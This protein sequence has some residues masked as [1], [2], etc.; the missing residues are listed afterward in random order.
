MLP[1]GLAAC[2]AALA[3]AAP[4]WAAQV[5]DTHDPAAG[6][7]PVTYAAGGGEI[8]QLTVSGDGTNVVFGDAFP[9][10]PAVPAPAVPPAA[11]PVNDCTS[12]GLAALCPFGAVTVTL[13][14]Q[15]DTI[16]TGAGAPALDIHGG[17][18][19]DVLFDPV[20]SPGTVFNGDAGVDRTDYTGRTAS[21]S[22]SLNGVADDGA[23]GEGDNIAGDEVVGGAGDDTITG[24]ASPNGL[25]G[26]DGNDFV[27]GGGGSDVL[28]GGAGNDTLDGG[29]ADDTLRGGDG[30]DQLVGG[31]GNDILVGGPGADS[32][33][34]GDGNDNIQAADGIAETID[35]GPGIDTVVADL[36][37]NGVTDTRIGCENVSGPAAPPPPAAPANR[38][39]GLVPV[40]APGVANP[41]DLTPPSAT[42]KQIA[43][44]KLRT[45]LARGVPLDVSCA[46]A[47]GVSISL[48][49]ERRT[50]RRLGLDA[51]FPPVVVATVLARRASPGPVRVRAR[52]TKKAKAALRRSR[53]V[54][55]TAQALVSDA[56][57]N[58]TLLT[59][60]VTLVR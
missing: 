34:G 19:N 57:G 7:G 13:G 42:L 53:R 1:G 25:T 30:A 58:G 5:A 22:V 56:S 6:P 31:P 52:F 32:I 11:T 41:A 21:L 36:G 59:R 27:S 43:R 46:E 48:S 12:T 18:G 26:G 35:C 8:N 23:S 33:S 60:R 39:A 16:R 44:V 49:V 20:F 50:A 2:A 37:A 55:L 38:P 17:T 3:C 40:L 54:T 15:N 10:T 29:T 28:D 9:I 24:N 51:R 45:A 4:A 47:C 14:D